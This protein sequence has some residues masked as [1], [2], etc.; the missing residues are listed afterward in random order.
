MQKTPCTPTKTARTPTKTASTPNFDLHCFV[1]MQF[2][3]Q[4]YALS[5][6]LWWFTGQYLAAIPTL[7]CCCRHWPPL[8]SLDNKSD[9]WHLR[10]FRHLI[11]VMSRQKDKR[12]KFT[13][14]KK[15]TRQ[16][17]QKTQKTQR[18]KKKTQRKKENHHDGDDDDPDDDQLHL[19]WKWK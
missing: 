18:K 9:F 16:I 10:P 8:K 12:K 11:R 3:S 5:H 2:L 15:T 4:I 14:T 6:H 19:T 17:Y 7:C 1:A 13:K